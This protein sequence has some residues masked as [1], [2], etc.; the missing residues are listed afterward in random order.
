MLSLYTLDLLIHLFFMLQAPE[1]D[2]L[3][4]FGDKC[5]SMRC[6]PDLEERND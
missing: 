2:R 4:A 5:I 6:E 1:I 3:D